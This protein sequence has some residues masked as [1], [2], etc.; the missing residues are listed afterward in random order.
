[1]TVFFES[2]DSV[3]SIAHEFKVNVEVLNEVNL[4][5]AFYDNDGYSGRAFV[6]YE[7][8]GKFFEVHANHC[9]CYGLED[10][11]DPEETFK[12]ALLHWCE[13][14]KTRFGVHNNLFH[15]IVKGLA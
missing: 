8:Y 9:S 11:W 2:F 4:L 15:E 6:L 5:F 7:K 10:Q 1:M 12:E 3:Q 13:N 14:G